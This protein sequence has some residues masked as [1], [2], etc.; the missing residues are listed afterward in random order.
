M[1]YDTPVFVNGKKDHQSGEYGHPGMLEQVLL[2]VAEQ[3]S[4]ARSGRLNPEPQKAERRFEN[5][6]GSNIEGGQNEDT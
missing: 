5:D 6:D 1:A 4:P 3:V 2:G